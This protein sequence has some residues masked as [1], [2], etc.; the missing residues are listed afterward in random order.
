MKDLRQNYTLGSL[1]E[2]SLPNE[3]FSLFEKWFDDALQHDGIIEPNAMVLSTVN[4]SGADSRIVLLKD[5]RDEEF[6]FFTNYQSN[7]GEQ[8]A[9][10]PNCSLLFPWINLQ[11]QI[12]IRGSVKKVSADES[13]EYFYSRPKSS[14]I[15]AWVS[16]QSSQ[17][18]SRQ[19]LDEKLKSYTVRFEK[20][21]L[22]RPPHWGGYAL[23][24][25][26][27]EFWQGRENRLHDRIL[28][29]NIAD[30]WSVSRLQ[31]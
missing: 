13:D 10:N 30:T 22:T 9:A 5:L 7:K 17:I 11:R 15:G 1:E 18:A 26:A 25:S 14:Q 12:I 19:E 29:R 23:L 31:P 4:K 20:E 21:E 8:L 27:I 28:F 6:V 2:A 24:P 3:P 16:D